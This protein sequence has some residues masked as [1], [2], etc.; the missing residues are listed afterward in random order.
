MTLSRYPLRRRPV[1]FTL[2][3]LLVVIAI[4]AILIGLLLPAVQKVREAANRAKCKNHLKQ[5]GLAVHNCNDSQGKL[6]PVHGW[7]P[8][9]TNVPQSGSGYGSVLFHL[10][11]YLEQGPLYQSSGGAYTISGVTIQAFTPVQNPAVYTTTVP[12]FQCPSDPSMAD[13]HPFGM[14]PGGAS[15]ACNFFAFGTA[16]GSYPK[17][18]GN[19]PYQVTSWNWWG[20]N[21]IGTSFIDGTSNT[22]LFAEKYAR[23][24]W[25]PN[26]TTGGGNMWAHSGTAGVASGQSWWPVVMAPDYVKYNPDCYGLTPGALFQVQPTPFIGNCDWTRAATGHTGGIQ[27]GLADGSVRNIAQG[28]S[29]ATW[30]YAFTPAGGEPTPSDW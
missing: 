6:P 22:I 8:A 13:G 21:R 23:C 3:E 20:A 11:P 2:I 18:I 27:V 24:E 16:A 7:F 25:P 5:I 26:S 9:S 17:G 19:P 15:Y 1:A 29:Y 4:I 10:L 12:V 28:I 30:W 14:T